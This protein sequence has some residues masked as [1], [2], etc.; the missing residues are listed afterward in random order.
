MAPSTIFLGLEPSVAELDAK[1][2]F[3]PP[4]DTEYGWHRYR[5]QLFMPRECESIVTIELRS[6]T[7]SVNFHFGKKN[8]TL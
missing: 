7:E 4:A 2:A 5:T 8:K 1:L 6:M 3:I